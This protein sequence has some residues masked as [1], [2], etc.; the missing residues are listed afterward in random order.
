MSQP[1]QLDQDNIQQTANLVSLLETQLST[2]KNKNNEQESLLEKQLSEAKKNLAQQQQLEDN[3]TPIQFEYGDVVLTIRMRE[4]V[5]TWLFVFASRSPT[6]KAVIQVIQNAFN[7]KKPLML[8][9]TTFIIEVNAMTESADAANKYTID[10]KSVKKY[11]RKLQNALKTHDK[12]KSDTEWAFLWLIG[13]VVSG[14][15]CAFLAA[16]KK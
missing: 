14:G 10:D 9:A 11:I 3:K 15:S 16:A 1:S 4:N 12:E 2:S 6:E 8:Q 13:A 5:Y 7:A